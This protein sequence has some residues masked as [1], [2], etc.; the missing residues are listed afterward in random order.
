MQL[1]EPLDVL[2]LVSAILY[3]ERTKIE[4]PTEWY[5]LVKQRQIIVHYI[6]ENVTLFTSPL[7]C[8]HTMYMYMHITNRFAWY[9]NF[10]KL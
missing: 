2:K 9:A 1:F 5:C 3:L 10:K 7:S 4:K 6:I 8:F